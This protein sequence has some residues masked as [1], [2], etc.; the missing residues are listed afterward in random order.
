MLGSS[1]TALPELLGTIVMEHFCQFLQMKTFHRLFD[2]N[3]ILLQPGWFPTSSPASLLSSLLAGLVRAETAGNLSHHGAALHAHTS[4]PGLPRELGPTLR[5][6]FKVF[7][8]LPNFKILSPALFLTA[9]VSGAVP[10][11]MG[12]LG[13]ERS[14]SCDRIPGCSLELWNRW[15]SLTL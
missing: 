6:I 15:A 13:R 7:V 12:S 4:E 8:L 1:D 5:R 10:A 14:G 2:F 9:L 3:K 11:A